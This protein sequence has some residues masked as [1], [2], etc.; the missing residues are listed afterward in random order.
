MNPKQSIFRSLGFSQRQTLLNIS[1]PFIDLMRAVIG[2]PSCLERAHLHRH[3]DITPVTYDFDYFGR[4]K[5]A[6]NLIH[7]IHVARSFFDQ[8]LARAADVTCNISVENA[9]NHQS[10]DLGKPPMRVGI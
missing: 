6:Q 2:R 7:V 1:F 9:A 4:G 10:C 5:I 8:Q 3:A